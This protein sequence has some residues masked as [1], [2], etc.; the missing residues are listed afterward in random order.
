MSDSAL[1]DSSL[2]ILSTTTVLILFLISI[3]AIAQRFRRPWERP[4]FTYW[5]LAHRLQNYLALL[6]ITEIHF[7]IL[8]FSLVSID[9]NH[10]CKTELDAKACH[11]LT[12][13]WKGVASGLAALSLSGAAIGY[14]IYRHL[15]KR[16]ASPPH[17]DMHVV[18]NCP[19]A[20]TIAHVSLQAS[21]A[22]TLTSSFS[23]LFFKP[24]D[25]YA[26]L[27]CSMFTGAFAIICFDV[28]IV[29]TFWG[30]LKYHFT[31]RTLR[32][33][34]TDRQFQTSATF[35]WGRGV[36]EATFYNRE[37]NLRLARQLDYLVDVT[38][39]RLRRQ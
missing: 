27:K 10:V 33:E 4:S 18:K 35:N 23:S 5:L 12:N 22:L 31:M 17:R 34:A 37:A 9:R 7:L 15:H 6:N 8:T 14:P 20:L 39:D 30:V 13:T 16:S 28:G 3:L 32:E 21:A 26:A 1:F 25:A 11:S 24:A 29:M 19:Y 38:S 36:A 2:T